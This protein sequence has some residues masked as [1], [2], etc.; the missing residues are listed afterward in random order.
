MPNSLGPPGRRQFPTVQRQSETRGQ[1]VRDNTVGRLKQGALA[2]VGA[3][4]K[5]IVLMVIP[6]IH[7]THLT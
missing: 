3:H 1:A 7:L 6:G 5:K 4:S 2:F